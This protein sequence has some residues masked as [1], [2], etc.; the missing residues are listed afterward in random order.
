MK[1]IKQVIIIRTSYTKD[2]K[3]FKPRTGKLMAQAAHASMKFIALRI[4]EHGMDACAYEIFTLTEWKWI[5][6]QK[7]TKIVVQVDTEQELLDLAKKAEEA[8][9]IIGLVQDYGL[10]EF[11]KPEYTAVGIGPDYADKID[12]IT[13][14]LKLY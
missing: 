3:P 13:K 5:V 2:G 14:D 12:P 4:K 10:T 9:I 7:F 8:G 1:S 6:E 11:E